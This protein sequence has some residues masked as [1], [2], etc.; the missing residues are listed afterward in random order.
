MIKKGKMILVLFLFTGFICTL[1]ACSNGNN[2]KES[3]W[4]YN[5]ISNSEIEIISYKG[6]ATNV[7]ISADEF[8]IGHIDRCAFRGKDPET[9]R[10]SIDGT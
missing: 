2:D 7:V 4:S 1:S 8:F 10:F 6:D 5:Y 9:E 3:L